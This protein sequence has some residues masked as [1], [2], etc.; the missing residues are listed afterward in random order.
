M[1]NADE[2]DLE[3]VPPVIQVPV[4]KKPAEQTC[5]TETVIFSDLTSVSSP[6]NEVITV[7]PAV[8]PIVTVQP[9]ISMA[10][11]V[12]KSDM[13]SHKYTKNSGNSKV[14][15]NNSQNFEGEVCAVA[16]INSAPVPV[17]TTSSCQS[18]GMLID[19]GIV[20]VAGAGVNMA[21]M[22][23]SRA[24]HGD[25]VLVPDQLETVNENGEKVLVQHYL[26]TS[27]T[28]N[29]PS[30][31]QTNQLIT[32]P[33]V[34]PNKPDT[35]G[36]AISAV[37]LHFIINPADKGTELQ[38]PANP[39]VSEGEELFD[40]TDQLIGQAMNNKNL[41]IEPLDSVADISQAENSNIEYPKVDANYMNDSS[42][43]KIN[44][45]F[46]QQNEND[47]DDD[48]SIR[49]SAGQNLEFTTEINAL[50]NSGP[51]L[52]SC[53]SEQSMD[54]HC[55]DNCS[56]YSG[57]VDGNKEYLLCNPVVDDLGFQEEIDRIQPPEPD[58]DVL[59]MAASKELSETLSSI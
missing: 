40:E 46:I 20:D 21:A 30:G 52:L 31:K 8:N 56:D 26:L 37:P 50:M 11:S 49:V 32:T 28:T 48:D 10:T 13:A 34:L 43:D 57:I 47:D 7:P 45:T 42:Q 6:E 5:R 2:Q 59:S 24:D 55:A 35:S 23:M 12:L 53:N 25:P 41:I 44:I 36:E 15:C 18:A 3:C 39:T 58:G 1:E 27:I 9:V 33:I 17:A 16:S 14:C 54:P 22:D 51:Q 4:V 38:V 29:T 19:R